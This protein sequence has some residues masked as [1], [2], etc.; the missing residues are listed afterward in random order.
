MEEFLLF[1]GIQRCNVVEKSVELY[2]DML[3]DVTFSEKPL[4][5]LAGSDNFLEEGVDFQ[6]L[7]NVHTQAL[8]EGGR[9]FVGDN[10]VN[11]AVVGV[12]VA[13]GFHNFLVVRL[14]TFPPV[15]FFA[16]VD[17]LAVTAA[18]GKDFL[19]LDSKHLTT[20]KVDDI[21]F[22]DP[23]HTAFPFRFG[24]LFQHIEVFVTAVNESDGVGFGG[25]F[26]EHLLFFFRAVP[27]EAEVAAY[28]KGIAP[29]QFFHLGVFEAVDISV[30][31]TSNIN[32][33][34]DL[35]IIVTTILPHSQKKIKLRQLDHISR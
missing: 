31:I 4:L 1:L 25:E 13:D 10:V 22:D 17:I 20:H 2:G 3:V 27:E 28:N 35:R 16:E 24:E 19:A 7:E 21:R 12:E 6:P 18:E 23:C 14:F 15:A 34:N 5:E 32:H 9:G 11:L 33:N 29:S 8:F 26:F 30:C